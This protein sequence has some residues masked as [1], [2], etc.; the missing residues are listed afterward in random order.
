MTAQLH[1]GDTRRLILGV[2]DSSV[3]LIVTDPPYRAI[4]GG[5]KYPTAPTGMLS[6][7]D[8][9]HFRYNDLSPIEYLPQ[10]Y[11][12]LKSPGHLYIMT[13]LLNLRTTWAALETA[14]FKV[15]NLL[16]WKKQNVTPSRWYMSNR[17]FILFAYKGSARP[18]NDCGSVSVMEFKNIKSHGHPT[19]KPVDLMRH[20]IENS[21]LPGDLVFD[22]FMGT[23]AVGVACS[24]RRFLG[25]EI[26]PRYLAVACQRMGVM[27]G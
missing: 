26:D 16:I 21:S 2:P 4:S 24:D 25:F 27:P 17:E 1:L 13:N 19:E 5:N 6:A 23:G 20:L 8:G 7:N 22:P 14:G 18:I 12:V 11:R 9:R 3:D 15:H 10:L